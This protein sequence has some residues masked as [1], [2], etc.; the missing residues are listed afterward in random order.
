[1]LVLYGLLDQDDL[2]LL[3]LLINVLILL[4]HLELMMP[5]LEQLSTLLQVIA[6]CQMI[7]VPHVSDEQ[8]VVYMQMSPAIHS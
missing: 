2:D 3:S 1:M 6:L 8:N 5:L 4:Y 7:L